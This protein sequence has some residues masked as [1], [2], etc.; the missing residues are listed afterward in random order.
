MMVVVIQVWRVG[1]EGM[2][3]TAGGKA[4]SNPLGEGKVWSEAGVNS[5]QGMEMRGCELQK[6]IC[7]GALQMCTNIM[8]QGGVDIGGR[9]EERCSGG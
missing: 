4:L 2:S 8:G 6:A 9:M 3:C 7:P 1:R 5:G